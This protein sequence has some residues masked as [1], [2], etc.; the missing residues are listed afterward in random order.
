M[1]MLTAYLDNVIVCG[2]IQA[3]LDAIEMAAVRQIELAAK[4]GRIQLL[5]SREAWREQDR[6]RN[7]EQRSRLQ[8][9]R[10]DIPVVQ[11]DHRLIGFHHQEGR[12][13]TVS[14]CPILTELVDGVLFAA[15]KNVG[16]K[17]GDARHLM[18]AVH[19]RCE[20][21]VTTDPDFL[22]RLTILEPLVRGSL[23][24]KPSALQ[25]ELNIKCN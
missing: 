19:N 17:D 24:L 10:D 23:I 2:S 16:L 9:S 6:T 13:G 1:P 21:F 22:D 15:F 7:Q 20:R 4:E 18:Y 3:D 12:Y 14:V 8:G 11:D 5:T 25:A